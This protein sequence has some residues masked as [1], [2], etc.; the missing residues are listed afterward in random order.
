MKDIDDYMDKEHSFEYYY[1]LTEENIRQT[2]F[3]FP[4]HVVLVKV[5]NGMKGIQNHPNET[6]RKAATKAITDFI[7]RWEKC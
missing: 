3:K 7:G 1:D 2:I 4:I 5:K 6:F